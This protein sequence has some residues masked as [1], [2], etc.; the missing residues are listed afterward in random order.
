[1]ARYVQD[2]FSNNNYFRVYTNL[3]V[4]GVELGGA[5]K[6]SIALAA[7][8]IAG[9][10]YGDNAKAAL[11]TRGL[12][13]MIRLGRALGANPLTF[14][15][16]TGI[17][18]LIVTCTSIH[19]RNWRA[20]NMLGKGQSLEDVQASM[21]M[22][23]E[24]VRTTEAVYQLAKEKNV[25]MPIITALYEVLFEGKDPKEGARALMLRMRKEEY[26]QLEEL[27]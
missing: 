2:L 18:D 1:A 7:G 11:M 12:A 13:E 14:S 6:N 21:G 10:G 23:I 16:L 25:D 3:D 27:H 19:S 17:G 24:G 22:V 20:G 26:E 15:G 4:V 8:L 5:I 9:L